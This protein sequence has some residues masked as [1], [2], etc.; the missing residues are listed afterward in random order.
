MQKKINSVKRRSKVVFGGSE[1]FQ[2]FCGVTCRQ[3]D[4]KEN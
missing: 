4:S 1:D 2:A 3:G